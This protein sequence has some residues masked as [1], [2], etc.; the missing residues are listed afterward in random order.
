MNLAAAFASY[1]AAL[2]ADWSMAA[3]RASHMAAALASGALVSGASASALRR[4]EGPWRACEDPQ[5]ACD[6]HRHAREAI[7]YRADVPRAARLAAG[8]GP[9]GE[10][11]RDPSGHTGCD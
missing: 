5:R 11:N 7:G 2:T 1:R 6:E 9:Q 10:C 8:C 3:A 4:D